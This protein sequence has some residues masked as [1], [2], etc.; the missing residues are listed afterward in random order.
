MNIKIGTNYRITSD[1][2]NFTLQELVPPNGKGKKTE[3]T[4]GRD[5]YY[6]RLSQALDAVMK[7]ELRKS[8]ATSIKEL[9]TDVA[10][11]V[12]MIELIA[13]EIINE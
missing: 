3:P 13:K 6:P 8:E 12:R 1:S 10:R 2:L 4:W 9:Q 7:H 5:K 11:C